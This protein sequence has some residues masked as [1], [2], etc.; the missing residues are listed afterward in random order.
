[1][2]RPDAPVCTEELRNSEQ[3]PQAV[4]VPCKEKAGN[5]LFRTVCNQPGYDQ[6]AITLPAGREAG[7]FGIEA[8]TKNKVVWGIRVEGGADVFKTGMGPAVLHGLIIGDT[9]PS[10]TGKYTIYLD[11]AAS[12]PDARITVRFVD[13]PR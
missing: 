9:A 12:D 6:V 5:L 7:C 2:E 3:L 11:T 10:S 13:Y 4:D 8:I 1:M